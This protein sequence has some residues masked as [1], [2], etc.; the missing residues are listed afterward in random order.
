M[1]V[2]LNKETTQL[3]ITYVKGILNGK[4][5]YETR[6]FRNFKV[7][8]LPEDVHELAVKISALGEQVTFGYKQEDLSEIKAV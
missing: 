2:S 3:L 1:A 5:T 6:R 4:T 7:G 8:V